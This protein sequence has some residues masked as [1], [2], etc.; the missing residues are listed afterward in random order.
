VVNTIDVGRA[1]NPLLVEGQIEGGT[2]MGVGYALMEEIKTENAQM[3]NTDFT[4][5]NIPTSL[6]VKK[7]QSIIVEDPEPSGPFEAKGFSEI[8]VT[9]VAPAILNAVY[10]AVGIRINHLPANAERILAALKQR[11]AVS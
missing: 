2:S 6:D 4:D 5:Y 7:L 11:G 9:A 8:T 1:I 3:Q 10:D